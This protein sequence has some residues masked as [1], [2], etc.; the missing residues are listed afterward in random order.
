[1][2]RVL[3]AASTVLDHGRALPTIPQAIRD[4]VVLRDRH[5]RFPGCQRGVDWCEVHHVRRRIDGGPDAVTNCVLLCAYHHHV[6]HRDGWSAH[7]ADDGT[8]V[9]ACPR[10]RHRTT[11]PPGPANGPPPSTGPLTFGA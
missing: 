6:L 8:L 7:L 9:V 1:M 5:C 10:G 11:R 4:V 3:T 2:R